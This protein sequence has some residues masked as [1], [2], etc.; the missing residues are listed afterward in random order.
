LYRDTIFT[1]W[2]VHSNSKNILIFFIK[3]VVLGFIPFSLKT[4]RWRSILVAIFGFSN[5]KSINNTL[6][7]SQGGDFFTDQ[8]YFSIH[9]L[10]SLYN[11]DIVSFL[12]AKSGHDIVK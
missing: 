12:L 2:T 11:W 7:L 6:E 5:V 3:N 4:G 1:F 10:N 8:C 9:Q